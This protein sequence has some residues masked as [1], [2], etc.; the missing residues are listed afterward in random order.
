MNFSLRCIMVFFSLISANSFGQLSVTNDN[1]QPDNSAMLDVKSTNKGLL[2]PRVALTAINSA[3][4]VTSPAVGLMV[5]NTA[6]AGIS[7]NNVT[8]GY[9]CWNG[10]RWMSIAVPLGTT[11]GDMLYW[12]GAQWVG[13]AAGLNG[14][15]LTFNNGVPSWAT[16]CGIPI[17][18]NHMAGAVAPVAKSV[19]YGTVTNIPGAPSKCWI[20]SN[21]GSDHQASAVDDGSE[22][23][24]GWYWQ[25]NRSQGYK[26]DGTTRTP[27]T[28]W[29]NSIS[30]NADW[31]AGNDP[32]LIELGGSWRIPTYT[33][34]NNVDASGNWTEWNGPWNAALKLHAAGNLNIAD[35][36][37]IVR[38]PNGNGGYWSSSQYNDI[39]GWHLSFNNSNSSMLSNSGKAFGLSIRCLRD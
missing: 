35:G 30:E 12:N 39:I 37:L 28:V 26:H 4:P 34:W 32:C 33:E 10:S 18:I 25:F 36:S 7:P 1:S 9:Y 5:Y 24:A 13:V 31:T 22:A 21:L 38:G 16:L 11:A 6:I 19:T 27:G 20:S 8:P 3:L 2:P 23:S 17:T 15:V 29:I 14:Q